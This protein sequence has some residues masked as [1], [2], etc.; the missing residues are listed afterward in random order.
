MKQNSLWVI[1]SVMLWITVGCI[2]VGSATPTVQK[3]PVFVPQP[4]IVS[5][6]E[7]WNWTS[8]TPPA[9]SPEIQANQ[10]PVS[11]IDDSGRLHFFWN[12]S[13]TSGTGFIYH[14]FLDPSG[15]WSTPVKAAETL[16]YS[17]ARFPALMGPDGKVHLLWFN[18][19]QYG[20]P[21]RLMYAVSDGVSW[22]PE[23]EV[24]RSENDDNLS[25]ILYFDP[26]SV[27]HAVVITSDVIVNHYFDETHTGNVWSTP[28]QIDPPVIAIVSWSVWP[29]KS[30]A[31]RFYGRDMNSRFVFT[32]ANSREVI[33][34]GQTI[35]LGYETTLNSNN[36]LYLYWMGQVSVP[37]GNVR[38]LH[39]RCLDSNLTLWPEIIPGGEAKLNGN[40]ISARTSDLR[41]VFVWTTD[42]GNIQV[43][44]PRSC[45]QSDLWTISLPELDNRT[46][47]LS[48]LAA[49][50]VSKRICALTTVYPGRTY[51]LYCADFNE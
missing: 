51:E 25:G 5:R 6:G 31:V 12:P 38:G 34:T 22:G 40:P 1:L 21:Y 33:Q 49:D 36:D 24:Y 39:M 41:V 45:A 46:R 32:L 29:D 7:S 44:I 4:E 11:F 8:L 18:S 17:E 14:S 19:L 26:Q 20:G 27:L 50:Q 3:N 28:I 47:Q 13:F 43:F 37:G 42:K 35:P 16:G 2:T 30:D 10:N 23:E 48:S 9:F 15:S